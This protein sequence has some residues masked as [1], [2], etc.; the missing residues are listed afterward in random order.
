VP[1]PDIDPQATSPDPAT[2]PAR[3]VSVS[4]PSGSSQ[5]APALFWQQLLASLAQQRVIPVVGPDAVIIDG[6]Y[7]PRPLVEYV[8]RRLEEMLE[9]G[10]TPATEHA[11][12]HDV[13]CRYLVE[14][15]GQID[16]L[17]GAV[18]LAVESQPTTPPP[19]L[20]KLARISAF[21]LYVTTTFDGL[22]QQAIDEERFHGEH[23]T[24]V[25]AYSP[26]QVQDLPVPVAALPGPLVYHLLGR[27]SPF[28][29]FVVTEEDT[30]EFVHS[31]QSENHRPHLLLDELRSHT[32]L[33]IGNGYSDWLARFFLRIAKR[34]RLL[35]ARSKTDIMA[36]SRARDDT[37]L[38]DF[39]RHFNTQTKIFAGGAIEFIDELSARWDAQPLTAAPQRVA[40]A[41]SD[42]LDAVFISYATEDVATAQTLAD[43]IRAAGLPVWFDRSGGL[44]GGDDYE[45]KIRESIEHASFFVP[46]LSPNVLTSQRRF[47]RLEWTIA[48]DIAKR[49]SPNL[50]FLVPVRIGDV[51]SDAPQVPEA[52]RRA[53]WMDL[54]RDG[55]DGVV[56]RLRALFREYRLARPTV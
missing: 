5:V 24:Q 55:M 54:R 53:Q 38:S 51:Q 47:F 43:A 3:L 25:L 46:V 17:Y 35:V 29:E 44:Q 33:I 30:L 52:L 49:A 36:D 20:R 16:E 2:T 11:T 12:L 56:Q 23:R 45:S 26:E 10:A 13:A 18:K 15:G 39:L 32:L 42:Q 41:V 22:L 27:A 48:A 7:G 6:E 1:T 9:L 14:R 19:A 28:P 21:S 50:P 4:R 31:L 8:A 40:P 37:S 34:E